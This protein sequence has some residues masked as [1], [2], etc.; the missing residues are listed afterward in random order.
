MKE[1]LHWRGFFVGPNFPKIAKNCCQMNPL[2]KRIVL[3]LPVCNKSKSVLQDF[4]FFPT[5]VL[6]EKLPLSD[7]MSWR[8]RW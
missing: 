4:D 7:T 1:D 6:G 2:Y 5:V 8:Y 3:L